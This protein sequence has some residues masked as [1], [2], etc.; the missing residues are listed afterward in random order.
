MDSWKP[1]FRNAEFQS[2]NS[3]PADAFQSARVELRQSA[4]LA[5]KTFEDQEKKNVIASINQNSIKVVKKGKHRSK[6]LKDRKFRNI[7]KNEAK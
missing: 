6:A 4:R 1:F 5:R 7:L 3:A 2:P